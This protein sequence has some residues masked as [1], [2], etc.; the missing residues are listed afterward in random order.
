MWVSVAGGGE[1]RGKGEFHVGGG[2]GK[3][4]CVWV[5]FIS[6]S[7]MWSHAAVRVMTKAPEYNGLLWT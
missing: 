3:G 5:A 6:L 4:G 7:L 2:D 1:W